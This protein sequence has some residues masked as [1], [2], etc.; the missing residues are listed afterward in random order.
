MTEHIICL[1]QY[2]DWCGPQKA[3][4]VSNGAKGVPEALE[5]GLVVHLPQDSAVPSSKLYQ[6][7][8]LGT[9]LLD[10]YRQMLLK[11]KPMTVEVC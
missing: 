10:E 5:Y 7:T 1:L 3:G 2:L 9:H 8:N 6:M 11:W 4:M